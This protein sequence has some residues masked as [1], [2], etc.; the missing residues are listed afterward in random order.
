MKS[1]LHI[2]ELWFALWTLLL[3]LIVLAFVYPSS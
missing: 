2:R 1:G 3:M